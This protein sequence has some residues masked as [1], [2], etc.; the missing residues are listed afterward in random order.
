[1]LSRLSYCPAV[2]RALDKTL[3]LELQKTVNF[4]ARVIFGVTKYGDV[5]PLLKKLNC[6][7]D[8]RGHAECSNGLL[9]VQDC[10]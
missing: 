6:M 1:M 10:K 7:V 9:H 8:C 5:T 3:M 2:W 4:A